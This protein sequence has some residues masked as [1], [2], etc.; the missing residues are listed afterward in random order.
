M[1]KEMGIR[2]DISAMSRIV[3]NKLGYNLKKKQF[4]R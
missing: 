2:I 3:R 4:M 1:E